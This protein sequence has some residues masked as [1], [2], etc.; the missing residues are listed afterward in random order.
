MS[1]TEPSRGCAL[2]LR[3]GFADDLV[4]ETKEI[5][6]NGKS[7]VCLAADESFPYLGVRAS[8]TSGREPEALRAFARLGVGEDHIFSAA[9]ELVGM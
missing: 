9:K 8:P 7:L 5:L 2:R 1:D 6:Y 3:R 4:L